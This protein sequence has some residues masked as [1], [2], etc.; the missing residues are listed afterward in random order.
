M[1]ALLLRHRA[2]LVSPTVRSSRNICCDGN[3]IPVRQTRTVDMI[4]S[5]DNRRQDRWWHDT[6]AAAC[7]IALRHD[8]CLASTPS[9]HAARVRSDYA[10]RV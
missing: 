7:Q 6:A 8:Y 5:I 1:R 3:H 2:T 10:Q 4:D 9:T